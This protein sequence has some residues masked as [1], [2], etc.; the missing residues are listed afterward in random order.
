M[1]LQGLLLLLL[2]LLLVLLLEGMLESNA[3]AIIRSR[4]RVP[5]VANEC[6][7]NPALKFTRDQND[8]CA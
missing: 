8:N 7:R 5:P 4:I 6:G 2:L 1:I 3:R